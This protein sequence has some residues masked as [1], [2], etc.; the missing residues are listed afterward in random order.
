MR[1]LQDAV[2]IQNVGIQNMHSLIKT[3]CSKCKIDKSETDYFFVD[4]GLTFTNQRMEVCKEC[5]IKFNESRSRNKY[6][7]DQISAQYYGATRVINGENLSDIS[8]KIDNAITVGSNRMGIQNFLYLFNAEN[9][10]PSY[11]KQMK[12]IFETLQSDIN[13]INYADEIIDNDGEQ[14]FE[15]TKKTITVNSYERNPTVRKKCIEHYGYK[16][17]VCDFDFEK[18]Y[19]DIGKSYIHIHHRIPLHSIGKNYEVDYIKDL[20]PVCPNCHSM[21]H[22]KNPP[23]T[24]EK[25]KEILNKKS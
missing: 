7:D 9:S 18:K 2:G 8:K 17:I 15:G 4:G 21:I 14:F 16:C 10:L 11:S 5:V 1:S 25:M 19:G 3:K 22:K 20:V 13:Q 24:I 23:F 12:Q 6:L